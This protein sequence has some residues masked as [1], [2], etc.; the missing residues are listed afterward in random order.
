MV[1]RST[2]TMKNIG[3][4]M[5]E[6]YMIQRCGNRRIPIGNTTQPSVAEGSGF[7][8]EYACTKYKSSTTLHLD[9]VWW[10]LCSLHLVV[11]NVYSHSLSLLS[12][13][14]V[15]VFW[16]PLWRVGFS[17]VVHLPGFRWRFTSCKTSNNMYVVYYI[18]Q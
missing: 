3:N 18:L 5:P 17:N 9:Y 4:R 15:T 2:S 14:V 7:G 12:T 11:S 16:N 1:R 8:G 13:H 6:D 10:H